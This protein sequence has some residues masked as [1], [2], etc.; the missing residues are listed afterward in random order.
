MR[1]IIASLTIYIFL[2]WILP[3]GV[4]IKSS[5]QKMA[6]DGQR[7]ICMCHVSFDKSKEKPLEGVALSVSAGQKNEN[8]NTS[9]GGINY[10]IGSR[11]LINKDL[12]LARIFENE[13]YR[14]RNPLL[15]ILD[16]VPKA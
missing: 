11:T 2:I 12:V 9:G 13:S 15:L 6:C 3:L 10:F 16:P 8:E 14:Y 5:L 7:A 4:F 1:R